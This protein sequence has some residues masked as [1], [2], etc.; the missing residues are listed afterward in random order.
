MNSNEKIE[1]LQSQVDVLAE[2]LRA[3][4]T[5]LLTIT[6]EINHAYK[7]YVEYREATADDE[8]EDSPVFTKPVLETCLHCNTLKNEDGEF[9]V[10]CGIVY[11]E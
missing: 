3:A 9:C 5:A 2:S 6:K 1:E 8:I 7:Q 10:V 11:D 4:A